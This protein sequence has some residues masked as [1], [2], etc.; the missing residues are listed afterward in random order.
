MADIHQAIRDAIR[1][2]LDDAVIEVSGEGGHFT[3]AVKS[4]AF[5]G[6][7]TLQ[8]HRLVLGAIKEL[9]AGAAAPVHAVDSIK[10]E[11]P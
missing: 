5:E 9:M 6:K 4:A 8:R 11:T 1:A 7:N 3:I 10:A 2:Q